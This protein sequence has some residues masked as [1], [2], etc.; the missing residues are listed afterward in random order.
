MSAT[1]P[2]PTEAELGQA[3]TAYLRDLRWDVYQEVAYEPGIADVVARQGKL[4]AVVEIKTAFSL[5]VIAQARRWLGH[6]H[7]TWI[8]VPAPQGGKQRDGRW[9]GQQVCEEL[10]VGVL[11][12]IPIDATSRKLLAERTASSTWRRFRRTAFARR[13]SPG[14]SAAHELRLS[15]RRCGQSTRRMR[16]RESGTAGTGRRSNRRVRS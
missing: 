3:V 14:F 2:K 7:F 11:E 5:E 4:V 13:P 15:R 12:V 1:Q 16:Q 10:G 9:L 6:A 8:A